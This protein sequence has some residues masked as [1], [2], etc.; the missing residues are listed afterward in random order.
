MPKFIPFLICFVLLTSCSKNQVFDR[1]KSIADAGWHKDSIIQF[2]LNPVDTTSRNNLYVQLRNTKDYKYSNLFLIV[3][4]DF[5]D[6]TR[7]VDTLEYEMAD[8]EGHF[9]GSGLTDLKENKL[10]YKTNVIFPKTGTYTVGIQHAMRRSGAVMGITNLEGISDVGLRIEKVKEWTKQ[11]KQ[12]LPRLAYTRD[13][14][15]VY[16]FLG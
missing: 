9:L 15:G 7:I 14:Y 3:G 16:L 11:K 13:G 4:I 6:A 10:E 12:Q 2:E 1:Y 5:P 8:A